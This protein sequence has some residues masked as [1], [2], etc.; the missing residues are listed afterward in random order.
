MHMHATS[1]EVKGV[2]RIWTSNHVVSECGVY[3]AY[4]QEYR[5]EVELSTK[6]SW[7]MDNSHLRGYNMYN[8]D[9]L[10]IDFFLSSIMTAYPRVISSFTREDKTTM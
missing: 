9:K 3:S 6:I 2:P 8:N 10:M 7:S 5:E 4:I 1:R